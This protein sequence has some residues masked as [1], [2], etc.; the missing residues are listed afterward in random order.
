MHFLSSN[1]DVIDECGFIEEDQSSV[2]ATKN[3]VSAGAERSGGQ[4]VG[5]CLRVRRWILLERQDGSTLLR[6]GR[7]LQEN[8]M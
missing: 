6:L 3:D 7:N 2:N 8:L 1:N 5:S 4:V